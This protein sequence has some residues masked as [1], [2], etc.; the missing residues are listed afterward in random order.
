LSEPLFNPGFAF[1]G[2]QAQLRLRQLAI[3]ARDNARRVSCEH[4]GLAILPE[5]VERHM[6]I[7]HGD[8]E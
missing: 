5:N 8:D 3:V 4:C 6:A 1:G 7:V 2:E